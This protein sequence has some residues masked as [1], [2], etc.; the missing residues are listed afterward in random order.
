MGHYYSDVEGEFLVKLARTTV[1]TYVTK[2]ERIQ[3]PPDT[4]EKLKK[5][6][7]VFTRRV[8][9]VPITII[10]KEKMIIKIVKIDMS[11]F[12]YEGKKNI[13]LRLGVLYASSL[14]IWAIKCL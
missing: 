10:A 1:D 8:F 12:I 13:K 2:K 7:G 9:M 14:V 5:E 4:P 6:S 3:P 11:Q